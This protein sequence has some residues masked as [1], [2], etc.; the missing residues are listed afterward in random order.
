MP[1]LLCLLT[2]QLHLFSNHHAIFTPGGVS[3]VVFVQYVL[4][5]LLRVALVGIAVAAAGGTNGNQT[6]SGLDAAIGDF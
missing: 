3:G 5:N 2:V 4:Q 6:L 1:K